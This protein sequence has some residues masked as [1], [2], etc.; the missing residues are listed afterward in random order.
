MARPVR[1][2]ALPVPREERGSALVEFVFL[3]VV[4][5]IPLVY[6]VLSLG[7]LQAGSYAVA[8][9][10]REAGRAF[11]TAESSEGAAARAE[12][13]AAIAFEDQGFGAEGGIEIS[14]S[15]A[16]CLTPEARVSVRARVRVPL[17]LVPEFARSVVPLEVP[18]TSTVT[19]AVDRFRS[20]P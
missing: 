3:S 11:V 12:A 8:A 6:L 15:A 7:R 13:A 2:A 1:D 4:L 20:A 9:A 10:A 5:L 19:V 14:C 18:V 17:P 16:P